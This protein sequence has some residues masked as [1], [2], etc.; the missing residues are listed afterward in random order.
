MDQ[1]Q[2]MVIFNQVIEAGSFSKAAEQLNIAKSSVSKRIS[3]LEK[4]L[5]VI[6]IQRS[7]R[8]LTITDEGWSLYQHSQRIVQELELAKDVAARFQ[9]KP[10]GTLR[11]TAPPLFGRLQ[12]SPLL[13]LFQAQYPK[14]SIE[15]FLTESYSDIIAKGYDI[16]L[17]MRDLP[18]SSLVVQPLCEIH[19]ICCAA[20]EYLARH[21]TPQ[22]LIELAHHHCIVWNPEEG[23]MAD[24]W[25]M[26]KGETTE[27][28]QLQGKII[29]NDHI[30][31]K[32]A[33]LQGGGITVLPTYAIKE[34]LAQG[35]LIRLLPDYQPA[36]F[37]IS[38]LYPKRD[39]VPAK[40]R[41]FVNFLKTTLSKTEQL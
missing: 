39:N 19:A 25:K 37:P 8:Q 21:G 15:L 7:T 14:V 18:D 9:E 29:C 40:T 10:Q 34:E 35:S 22:S 17:R 1:L 31:I 41:A 33:T 36:S 32:Q 20:P 13:P 2:G 5:G 28:I 12:L 16:C 27:K 11:I 23:Q 3:A 38:I 24:T 30:A 6:L 4:E 26:R